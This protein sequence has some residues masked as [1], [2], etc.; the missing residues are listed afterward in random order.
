MEKCAVSLPFGRMDSQA[1]LA[2]DNSVLYL[3]G[4]GT[5]E[6]LTGR[7]VL[8]YHHVGHDAAGYWEVLPESAPVYCFAMVLYQNHLLL[9]GGKDGWSNKCTRQLTLL[10]NKKRWTRP[11]PAMPTARSLACAA[12]RGSLVAVAGGD[13]DNLNRLDVVELFDG[14]RNQWFAADP[15]PSPCSTMKSL[16]HDGRWYLTGGVGHGQTIKCVYYAELENLV[17]SVMH[18]SSTR[19][20]AWKS[21]PSNLPY[22]RSSIAVVGGHLLAVGGQHS[23]QSV[24]VVF[25]YLPVTGT[26]VHVADMPMAC[27]RTC[28]VVLPSGDL[29]V[30]G[31]K[32]A[33]ERHSRLVHK[34]V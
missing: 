20:S 3:G 19:A 18:S 31:G 30:I 28:S 33:I 8:A 23:G 13:D 25:V 29:L 17:S 32:T 24:P 5:G 4:G 27:C 22:E 11:L 2:S 14:E 16:V 10:E 1:V 9:C 34:G 21:L 6:V 12:S 15:L 7:K 26:W